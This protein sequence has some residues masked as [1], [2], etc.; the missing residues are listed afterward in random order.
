MRVFTVDD[1]QVRRDC[2][3]LRIEKKSS[4]GKVFD[5]D[6]VKKFFV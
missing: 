1:R 3:R 5:A 4:S 6:S 2:K